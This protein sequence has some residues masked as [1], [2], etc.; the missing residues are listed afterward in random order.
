MCNE[1][2]QYA[3]YLI[4]SNMTNIWHICMSN[5]PNMPNMWHNYQTTLSDIRILVIL[6][7]RIFWNIKHSHY[8]ASRLC[9]ASSA[10]ARFWSLRSHMYVARFARLGGCLINVARCARR[11]DTDN[12]KYRRDCKSNNLWI[13]TKTWKNVLFRTIMIFN[14]ALK[15]LEKSLKI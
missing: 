15:Y 1:Y 7:F 12:G 8:G 3:Q 13:G 2:G 4:K 10:R 5:M 6:E 14:I 11:I 9:E